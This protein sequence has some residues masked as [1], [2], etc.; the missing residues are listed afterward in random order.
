M[1][2][3]KNNELSDY[4]EKTIHHKA[5]RLAATTRDPIGDVDDIKQEL[6]SDLIERLPKF[7]PNKAAQNTFVARLI[8]HK[9][10]KLVRHGNAGSRDYR[11]VECSVNDNITDATGAKTQRAHTMDM[12]EIDIRRGKRNRPS[13]DET[14]LKIDISLT[15]SKLSPDD[16]RIAA[17]L[18]VQS[19]SEAAKTL[20]MPRTTV[21]EARKRIRRIFEDA[22]LRAYLQ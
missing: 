15:L 14:D 20:R 10:S 19:I 9:I 8:D 2:A 21:Y 6:R 5:H 18:K 1:G 12:D 11:R 3:N 16:Q 7:D 17:Q 13:Q 4:A 22:G